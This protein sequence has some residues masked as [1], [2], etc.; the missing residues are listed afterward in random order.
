MPGGTKLT[1]RW[2]TAI[3]A[4]LSEPT[5]ELAAVKASISHST[6]KNWLRRPDFQRSYRQARQA[7]LERTVG[8][9]LVITVDAVETLKALLS[10]DHPATRARAALGILEQATRGVELLDMESR[11]A[12]LEAAQEK[13]K[14]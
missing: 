6:L 11:L 4:L 3:A 7:V 8:R 14:Q 12:A 9:L 5:V 1:H 13:T 2:E 10:C